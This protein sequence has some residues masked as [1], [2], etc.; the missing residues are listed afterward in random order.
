MAVVVNDKANVVCWTSRSAEEKL[1]CDPPGAVLVFTW[2]LDR[3]GP[4]GKAV[5]KFFQYQHEDVFRAGVARKLGPHPP[6]QYMLYLAATSFNKLAITINSAA[7]HLSY[8][9][10]DSASASSAKRVFMTDEGDHAVRRFAAPLDIIYRVPCYFTF[11]IEIGEENTPYEHNIGDML[12]PDQMWLAVQQRLFTDVTFRVDDRLFTAHRSVLS[13]RSP[14]F[15]AMLRSEQNDS[16][17]GDCIL[18][19]GIDAENFEH[20]L[21]FL[22]TGQL[23]V[24]ANNPQLKAAADKYNL[25]TLKNMCTVVEA[26]LDEEEV[27]T[28]LLKYWVQTA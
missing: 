22:Y 4:D 16:Q 8:S 18:I 2:K 13:A 6:T 28:S 23:R 15:E 10:A 25:I 24:S 14:V 3:T 5:S 20:L 21:H 9:E 1:D 7:Y 12:L 11:F 17:A 19:E 27:T 26:S